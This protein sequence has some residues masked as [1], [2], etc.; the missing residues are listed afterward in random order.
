DMRL[1]GVMGHASATLLHARRGGPYVGAY[2]GALET[3]YDRGGPESASVWHAT[4]MPMAG[5]QW[6]PF[7]KRG[8]DGIYLEPW[9]GLSIWLPV[10][11]SS[12]VAGQTFSEPPG[13]P[14]PAVHLGYE[15]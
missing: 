14:F 13:V 10:A 11:G 12:T 9:L 7:Q 15:F 2:V 6:F 1:L 8:L 3:S 5:E 4:V